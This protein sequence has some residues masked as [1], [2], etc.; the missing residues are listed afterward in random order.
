MPK[1]CHGLF[2]KKASLANAK[3]WTWMVLQI[4]CLKKAICLLKFINSH[5]HS[6]NTA[7]SGRKMFILDLLEFVYIFMQF[8]SNSQTSK[9]KIS[10]KIHCFCLK[11]LPFVWFDDICFNNVLKIIDWVLN[12][13]RSEWLMHSYYQAGSSGRSHI[14]K[15]LTHEAMV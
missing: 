15:S 8:K 12:I 9:I 4:K 14:G 10:N 7:R 3:L 13:N 5:R 11:I 2:L 1:I 6:I